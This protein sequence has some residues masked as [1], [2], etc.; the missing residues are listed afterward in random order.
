M[1]SGDPH[2]QLAIAYNLIVDNRRIE[3]ETNKLD[4]K[5]FYVASS[6]P[7]AALLLDSP[8]RPQSATSHRQRFASGGNLGLGPNDKTKGTPMKRA[9]WHLGIRS[10]SKPHDIMNEVYRAMKALD[11]VSVC[12]KSMF[13]LIMTMH[14]GM[15][16]S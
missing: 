10:Q 8:A 3:G 12:Q 9:K 16:S 4:F 11:F 15:E 13:N 7:P 6:P 1:L 2:D 14:L 5:D